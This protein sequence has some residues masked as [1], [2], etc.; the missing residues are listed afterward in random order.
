MIPKLNELD[1]KIVQ[2]ETG[3]KN[4]LRWCV[5]GFRKS[6]LNIYYSMKR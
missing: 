4:M 5:E 1:R 6:L 2:G 3:G